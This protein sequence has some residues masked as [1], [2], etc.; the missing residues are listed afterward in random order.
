MADLR[1]RFLS[2]SGFISISSSTTRGESSS[3]TLCGVRSPVVLILLL[4]S[5]SPGV[6]E[7]EGASPDFVELAGV[8]SDDLV[9]RRGGIVAGR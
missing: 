5:D 3:L 8:G 9:D 7:T 2:A 6:E 4:R 1:D